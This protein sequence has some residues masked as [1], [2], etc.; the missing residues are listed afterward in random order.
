MLPL[1]FS[2]TS[3]GKICVFRRWFLPLLRLTGI[4]F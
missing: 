2:D 4:I 3:R 1:H